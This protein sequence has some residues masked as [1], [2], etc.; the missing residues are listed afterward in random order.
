MLQSFNARQLIQDIFTNKNESSDGLGGVLCSNVR[1]CLVCL[2]NDV[3]F[4]SIYN[5]VSIEPFLPIRL[6]FYRLLFYKLLFYRLLFYRLLF[7]RLQTR[8]FLFLNLGE[9]FLLILFGYKIK[10]SFFTKWMIFGLWIHFRLF[11]FY[12]IS[13][14][15][16]VIDP[17]FVFNIPIVI[18]Q[19]I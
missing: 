4:K 17:A 19:R 11:H 8:Y 6:L 9:R 7:Y 13:F 14:W 10:P 18:T 15:K 3:I 1:I 12:Y 5:K 2:L 16:Y